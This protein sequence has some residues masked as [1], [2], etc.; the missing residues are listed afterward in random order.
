MCVEVQAFDAGTL[1]L[2]PGTAWSRAPTGYDFLSSELRT[3]FKHQQERSQEKEEGR[4][5]REWE[6]NTDV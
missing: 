2:I 5:G 3:D 1:S 4:K 6:N